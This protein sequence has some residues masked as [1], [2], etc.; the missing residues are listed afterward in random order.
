M[1]DSFS[2]N[3]ISPLEGG[4]FSAMHRYGQIIFALL[5]REQERRRQSPLESMADILEPMLF[6]CIMGL[7]WTFL[8]RRTTSPLGDSPML[9]IAT[10]FYAKF[11]W[12]S[13]SK[14]NR[15]VLGSRSRRFPVER[16]FDY[17]LVHIL[18]TTADYGLLALVGFGI[19]YFFFTPNA[20]PDNFIPVAEGMLAML[21][22]GF[23]WGM[24]TLVLTRYFWPWPYF[25]GAFNR[26]M[27]LFSGVF[28]LA[29]FLPPGARYIMSFNPMLHAL[30]LFRTGFYPNYPKIVLD[31]NYLA[32]C[33]LAAVVIGFML[34]RVTV[35]YED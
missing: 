33:S 9:F 1:A 10:G 23:G 4:F 12:I 11:Y 2:R 7:V 16:R 22:L 8:N 29:E 32:C 18:L 13:I 20:I 17:I 28:F 27:L 14:M 25:A 30:A 34:E 5:Q 31:T 15:S 35:R 6:V 19:L 26:C 21:A 24:I 3:R